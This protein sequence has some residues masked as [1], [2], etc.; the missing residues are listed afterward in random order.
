MKEIKS[1]QSQYSR[2]K[3]KDHLTPE[4]YSNLGIEDSIEVPEVCPENCQKEQNKERETDSQERRRDDGDL[5]FFVEEK[6]ENEVDE[7][8]DGTYDQ[9]VGQG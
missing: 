7:Q 9:A 5:D 6:L 8:T 2:D 4:E 1:D 3:K